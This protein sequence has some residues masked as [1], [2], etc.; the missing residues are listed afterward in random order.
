MRSW[1]G[2]SRW[3]DGRSFSDL[4]PSPGSILCSECGIPR[5]IFNKLKEKATK[6]MLDLLDS[7]CEEAIFS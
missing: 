1:T 7:Y 2:T 5:L 3:W 4:T 6:K